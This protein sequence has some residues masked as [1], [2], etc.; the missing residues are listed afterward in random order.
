MS[1]R[2][3]VALLI[4]VAGCSSYVA[5]TSVRVDPSA[6]DEACLIAYRTLVRA[7]FKAAHAPCQLDASSVGAVT[8]ALLRTSCYRITTYRRS[9]DAAFVAVIENL[10]FE[11]RMSQNHSWWNPERDS[12]EVELL[13]HEQ[14]HFAFSELAARGANAHIEEIRAR[15]CSAAATE[16]EAIHV[17]RTRLQRELDRVQS[18]IEAR[19][20]QFDRDTCNGRH[21]ES[22]HRWFVAVQR[23][24]RASDLIAKSSFHSFVLTRFGSSQPE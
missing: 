20:E 17:A 7:D 4:L 18:E 15:T 14:T 10:R 24:L 9:E 1:A 3:L 22:S 23:E 16:R 21:A 11:A 6:L 19:N 8:A 2:V 12:C 13:E 5:P